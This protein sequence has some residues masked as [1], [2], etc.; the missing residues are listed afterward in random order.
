M[1][2]AY[3]AR[4]EE[5]NTDDMLDVEAVYIEATRVF[6]V[7]WVLYHLQGV[8]FEGYRATKRYDAAVYYQRLRIEFAERSCP[9]ASYTLAWLHEELADCMANQLV[10]NFW[11]VIDGDDPVV[12]DIT[13]FEKKAMIRLY[14]SATNL[15]L[16]NCGPQH[17]YTLSANVSMY[18]YLNYYLMCFSL[19]YQYYFTH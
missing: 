1:E 8:L 9:F 17:D 12:K 10:E 16:V 15:L 3:I 6:K 14:E 4:L 11:E 19:W 5:T 7:H 18:Y 2:D 13:N